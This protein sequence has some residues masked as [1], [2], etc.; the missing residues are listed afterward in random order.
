MNDAEIEE[1]LD[2]IEMVI[3]DPSLVEKHGFTFEEF[4]SVNE[5]KIMVLCFYHFKLY[6]VNQRLLELSLDAVECDNYD[7][8]YELV[9]KKWVECAKNEMT[10]YIKELETT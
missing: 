3:E 10:Q 4:L 1:C 9:S 7:F 2:E 5:F 8:I 6:P